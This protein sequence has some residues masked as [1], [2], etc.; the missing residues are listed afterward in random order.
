M[1]SALGI[2][3]NFKRSDNFN[4]FANSKEKRGIVVNFERSDN[5]NNFVNFNQVKLAK[6]K[7]SKDDKGK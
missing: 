1:S 5:F 3:V 4:N 2:V 7:N 6:L